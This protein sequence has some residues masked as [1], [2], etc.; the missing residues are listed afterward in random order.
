[1]DF[2]IRNGLQFQLLIMLISIVIFL[3]KLLKGSVQF[4]FKAESFFQRHR[5]KILIGAVLLFPGHQIS[6]DFKIIC[7]V[8]LIH[9]ISDHSL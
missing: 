7:P 4:N 3:Y 6:V 1:M 5:N 8:F 9:L 2:S